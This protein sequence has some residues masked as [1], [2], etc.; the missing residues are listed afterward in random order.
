MPCDRYSHDLNVARKSEKIDLYTDRRTERDDKDAELYSDQS[1]METVIESRH[2]SRN[3]G[4]PPTEIVCKYFLDALEQRKCVG[5]AQRIVARSHAC[6]YQCVCGRYG[7]FWECPNGNDKCHYRHCL[8][9][10]YVLKSMIKK[11]CAVWCGV[12]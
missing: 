3:R 8:P 6:V 4:L 5:G 1:K 10:G 11:V 7:W 2:G 9:A 12:M